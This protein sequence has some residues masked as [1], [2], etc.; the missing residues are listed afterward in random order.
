M[1][2]LKEIIEMGYEAKLCDE[3]GRDD[4]SIIIT[5][6][7]TRFAKLVAAKERER[8]AQMFEDAPALVE[9]AQN[10]KGGCLICGFTPKIAARSIR[11]L[12]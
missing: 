11:E 4:A 8:V 3:E 1:N 2:G 10:D 7:M 9:F 6:H 5:D 12:E